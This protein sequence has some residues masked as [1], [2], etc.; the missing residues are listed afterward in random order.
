MENKDEFQKSDRLNFRY[1]HPNLRIRGHLSAPIINGGG[2]RVWKWSKMV[3]FPTFMGS[4]PWPWI[5]AW[6]LPFFHLSSSTAWIPNFIEIKETFC[7]RTDGNLPPIV[8]GR[9]PKFGSQPKNWQAVP[10]KLN[11]WLSATGVIWHIHN[12]TSADLNRRCPASTS[13]Y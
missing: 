2:D 9:L 1:C 3:E 7:G 13:V 11:S 12:V 10:Y 4:W 6:A 5:R 8:L